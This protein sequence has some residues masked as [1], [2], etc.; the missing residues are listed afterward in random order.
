MLNWVPIGLEDR[1]TMTRI[2]IFSLNKVKNFLKPVNLIDNTLG[3]SGNRASETS[4]KTAF[5]L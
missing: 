2:L 1:S 3:K 4:F 5:K